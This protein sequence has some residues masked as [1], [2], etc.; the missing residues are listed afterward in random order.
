MNFKGLLALFFLFFLALFFSCTKVNEA[1]DLGDDLIPAV[2]NVNTFDTTL[3]V[4]AAYF[5][6][7]DPSRHILGELTALGQTIDP[8]FGNTTADMYFNLSST[9]Y[10]SKP[11]KD[12]VTAVDSVVLSLAYVAAYG[13]T[14]LNSQLNVAVSE[15]NPNNG[16]YDSLLYRYDTLGFSTGPSIGT[17]SFSIPGFKDSVKISATGKKGDT[18]KVTNVV[19]IKLNTSLATKLRSFDTTSGTNGGYKNDSIFR[20]LFRGL[21]VKTTGGNLPG[22]LAY[23]SLSSSVG[24]V[25]TVYYRS[26]FNGIKDTATAS[27]V[28]F[29]NGQANIIRRT[30]GGEYLAK[31]NNVNSQK[32]YI[33]SSPTGSY[34]GMKIPNLDAFPNKV[35][36]RAE[37]IVYR[38]PAD[39]SINDN[40]FTVPN[41]LFLDHK[42][43]NNGK[44]TAF[45]FDNDIQAGSDGSLNFAA[46][47]G[48][49]RS[50]DSYRFNLTRY[51]QGI[52][53]R[54]NQN[55]SLRLSAP[56]RTTL[57][58]TNL[59]QFVSIGNLD[60]I[61]KG[62]VVI[63]NNNFPDQSKRLRL[64]I[65]YS[66][67]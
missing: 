64:R 14:S 66:N 29:T 2:D 35:I 32:L 46:F 24:T 13:D 26:S 28:H 4:Q 50:D 56:L 40:L 8:A 7:E 15:I 9:V 23:F 31:G 34:V 67:L 5:P 61:A 33:Q 59:N 19:R 21:A 54:K 12:T 57:F 10:G 30:A 55:D 38:V 1:T 65:I 39:N 20:T 62:R 44:D 47:G 43:T 41:R 58:A 42:R 45:L 60:L 27:F 63:A 22:T 52:V 36:H 11:F 51:V 6:F 37:L 48:T 17:A 18:I 16:F 25:L 3:E 49:L 53:T